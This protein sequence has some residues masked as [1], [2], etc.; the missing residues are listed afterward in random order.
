MMVFCA[1]P[2]LHLAASV[3]DLETV[4]S[5]VE[6]GARLEQTD[7]R[8]NTPLFHAC[9]GG[10]GEVIKFLG[11]C[12]AD[13][14][15]VDYRSLR[16]NKCTRASLQRNVL[17]SYFREHKFCSWWVGAQ[18]HD[19]TGLP[20]SLAGLVVEYATDCLGEVIAEQQGRCAVQ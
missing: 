11:N 9:Q 18:V 1:V 14:W 4:R 19:A 10:H 12:G 2:R 13:E 7:Q 6:K 5:L 16:P 17:N 3:G 15:N 8:G 20:S